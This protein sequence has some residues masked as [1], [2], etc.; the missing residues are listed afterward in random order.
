MEI[1]VALVT[2]AMLLI[3]WLND[4]MMTSPTKILKVR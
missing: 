1:E 4:F 2:A 3:T